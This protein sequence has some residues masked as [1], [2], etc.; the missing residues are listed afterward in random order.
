M[1]ETLVTKSAKASVDV[2]TGQLNLLITGLLAGENI[3]ECDMVYIKSDGLVWRATAASVAAAAKAVG[4]APR[5]ANTGEPC[6]IMPGPGQ[7][8][9]YSDALLTPGAVLYLAETAGGL[10]STPTTADDEGVAQAIDSSNIRLTKGISGS[11]AGAAGVAGVAAGY[12]IARGSQALGGTNPTT[13]VTGLATV[14]AFVATLNATAAPGL[15]TTT[16]TS[17][18]N[19]TPGSQDVYAWKPTSNA[20][21]TLIASTGTENFDWIAIGT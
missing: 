14:V 4:I 9:R 15:G 20:N 17:H 21:P 11:G 5:Q 7:V 19:A 10:S 18:N 3:A 12:K 1:A 16:L 13:V 6:T 2:S 8:A